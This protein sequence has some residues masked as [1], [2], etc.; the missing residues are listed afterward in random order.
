M[1]QYRRGYRTLG[2]ASL[3]LLTGLLL[4]FD[5]G[6]RTALNVRNGRVFNASTIPVLHPAYNR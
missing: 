5:T 1:E 4:P 2:L 6:G 3:T